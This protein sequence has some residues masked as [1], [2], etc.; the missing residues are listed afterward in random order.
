MVQTDADTM[1][2]LV[3]VSDLLVFNSDQMLKDGYI[4]PR[5]KNLPLMEDFANVVYYAACLDS[6]KA[7]YSS[8]FNAVRAETIAKSHR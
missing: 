5:R 1:H 3:E 6:E 7:R 8:F 2:E 4:P